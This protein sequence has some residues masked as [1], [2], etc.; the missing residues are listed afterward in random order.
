MPSYPHDAACATSGLPPQ[1]WDQIINGETPQERETR[2]ATATAICGH[3]PVAS[4]CYAKRSQGGG[5][6]AGIVLPDHSP[7]WA[8]ANTWAGVDPFHRVGHGTRGG[9]TLHRR[10]GQDACEYCL[11]ANNHYDKARGAGRRKVA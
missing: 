9:Y 5:I 6:R 1:T 7:D 2:Y 10:L 4:A 11:S 8:D 3:C